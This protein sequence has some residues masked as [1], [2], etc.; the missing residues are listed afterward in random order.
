MGP[1]EKVR[2]E[3][4]GG[5]DLAGTGSSLEVSLAAAESGRG[6]GGRW[7]Q[8]RQVA[9]EACRPLLGPLKVGGRD[10]LGGSVV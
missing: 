7:E 3:T 5:P 2:V 6:Q 10:F 4:P 9:C 1:Q 8:Q